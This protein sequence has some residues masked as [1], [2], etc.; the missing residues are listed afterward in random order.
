MNKA[1]N[2][3]I[4]IPLIIKNKLIRDGLLRYFFMAT[5]IEKNVEP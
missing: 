3:R 5:R 4:D 1:R 2:K